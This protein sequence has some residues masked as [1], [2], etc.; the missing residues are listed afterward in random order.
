MWAFSYIWVQKGGDISPVH[1]AAFNAFI[2]LVLCFPRS[3]RLL[4]LAH[5]FGLYIALRVMPNI[6]DEDAWMLHLDAAYVASAFA[7]KGVS[8][9]IMSKW[10]PGDCAKAWNIAC[11]IIRLQSIIFYSGAFVWKLNTAFLDSSSSCPTVFFLS[12]IDAYLPSPVAVPEFMVHLISSSAPHL[13]ELIEASIP[14]LMILPGAEPFA[15]ILGVAF[16]WV[17]GL[18]PPP[19]NISSYGI[20]CSARY[21]SLLPE[22]MVKVDRTI[23]DLLRGTSV[24]LRAYLGVCLAIATTAIAAAIGA[25]T[26]AMY[27][28]SSGAEDGASADRLL[29]AIVAMGCYLLAGAA[30]AFS[31]SKTTETTESLARAS[32][33]RW[34][35]RVFAFE[36]FFFVYGLL[37]L[38]LVDNLPPKPFSSIRS[39]GGS[40]HLFLPTNLLG[41]WLGLPTVP[42]DIL[43]VEHSTSARMNAV[44]PSEFTDALSPGT[45]E[46]LRVAGHSGRVF[47][48]SGGR[49]YGLPTD[50]AHNGEGKRPFV[51]Y[52]LPAFELR[53]ILSEARDLNETFSVEYRHLPKPYVAKAPRAPTG[54]LPLVR[55]EEDGKAGTQRCS[56]KFQ[57]RW[58]AEECAADE[59]ALLPPPPTWML[60]LC[61]S[62]PNVILSD[63]HWANA[64]GHSG[65]CFWD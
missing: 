32:P 46:L 22:A 37:M 44:L 17:I 45:K 58:F 43:L 38:G 21:V 15:V 10:S 59:T 55:L 29:P 16:H 1:E 30:H 63:E 57:K 3:G 14:L 9:A 12:I 56:V 20:R 53:R 54:H 42:S 64:D 41:N 27:G 2:A 65:Y 6:F 51:R 11:P 40:N 39:Q 60:K 7:A 62:W 47:G 35:H 49:N 4:C 36:A 8:G 5:L 48:P 18:T 34:L 50:V 24:N 19:H 26:P 61:L 28:S 23:V 25:R 33:P 13:T 31:T 52:T